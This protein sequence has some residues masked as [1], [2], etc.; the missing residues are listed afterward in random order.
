MRRLRLRRS[1]SRGGRR[2]RLV[3]LCP[4]L[5]EGRSAD[6]MTLDGEDIVDG[7]VGGEEALG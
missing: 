7:G 2:P 5:A 3:S 4:E 6:Q 1:C